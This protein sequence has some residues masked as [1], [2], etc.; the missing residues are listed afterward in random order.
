MIHVKYDSNT[1][2]SVCRINVSR[3][4]K[5]CNISKIKRIDNNEMFWEIVIDARFFSY[6]YKKSNIP[7][8]L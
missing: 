1:T 4:R 7:D 3:M 8:S 5:L 6:G 2:L